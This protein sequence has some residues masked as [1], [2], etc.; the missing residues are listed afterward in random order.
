MQILKLIA[1]AG[2]QKTLIWSRNCVLLVC[3]KPF[4]LYNFY[5]LSLYQQHYLSAWRILSGT[6]AE[7]AILWNYS[8][9]PSHYLSRVEWG[10]SWRQPLIFWEVSKVDVWWLRIWRKGFIWLLLITLSVSH[11][12]LILLTHLILNADHL[13]DQENKKNEKKFTWLKKLIPKIHRGQ[14]AWCC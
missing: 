13:E 6:P 10:R 7:I 11:I 3:W 12:I 8:R 4:F 9:N 14:R 1:L 5:L 2:P